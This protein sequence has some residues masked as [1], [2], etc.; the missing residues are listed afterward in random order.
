MEDLNF[1]ELLQ[2][3][4][5]EVIQREP[6]MELWQDEFTVKC[7]TNIIS[8]ME[9]MD[10]TTEHENNTFG[11]YCAQLNHIKRDHAPMDN[12]DETNVFEL[13]LRKAVSKQRSIA[14]NSM[15]ESTGKQLFDATNNTIYNL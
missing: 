1:K 2:C 5:S 6:N 3:F 8:P 11:S 10:K 7:I 15:I 14:L 12:V 4:P 13:T 9:N